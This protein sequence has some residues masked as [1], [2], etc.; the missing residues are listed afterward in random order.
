MK[1]YYQHEGITI[2]HG[3]CREILPTLG[4]VDLVLT[5]PPYGV[6]KAEWDGSFPTEWILPALR[7][8]PRVL[9]ASGCGELDKAIAAFGASYRDLIILHSNNGMTRAPIGFGDR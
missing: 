1:P 4:P 2:Y 9:C 5:D 3:D 7:I 8:A 6:G